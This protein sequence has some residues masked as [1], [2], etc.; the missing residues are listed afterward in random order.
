MPNP[1][2]LSPFPLT[3]EFLADSG[4]PDQLP[5][6]SGYLQETKLLP[7]GTANLDPRNWVGRIKTR[8]K[9]PGYL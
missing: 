7:I 5:A 4:A 2:R 3:I 6:G 1:F 9:S 8:P